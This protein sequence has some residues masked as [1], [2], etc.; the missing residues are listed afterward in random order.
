MRVRPGA[1]RT[2]VGG[3][4]GEGQLVVAVGK[5][6]VD[7]A[8]NAAVIEAVADAFGLR[9]S[10]VRLISGQTGRSKVLELAADPEILAV[11]LVEL[12]NK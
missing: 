5:P 10:D 6:P 1:S 11:R 3:S 12:I 8:A 7:G 2:A 4:Y 9:R